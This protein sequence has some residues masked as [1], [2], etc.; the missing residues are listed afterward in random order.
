[1][2]PDATAFTP[3]LEWNGRA[4]R[5]LDQTLLP[6]EETWIGLGGAGDTAAAIA[7]LA[8]RGAPNIGI[9]AAYGLAMQIERAPGD[10]EVRGAASVLRR[11]RP[12]AVNL[13]WAVDQVLASGDPVACAR[14]LH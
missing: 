4:L 14:R 8:V 13:A 11:A 1:M 9:A 3:A 5:L 2:A 6:A 10:E 7:R 12:T